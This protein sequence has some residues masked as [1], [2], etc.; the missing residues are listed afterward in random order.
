MEAQSVIGRSE[1]E[2]YCLGALFDHEL[3]CLLLSERARASYK[4]ACTAIL[5]GRHRVTAGSRE[6][7][8]LQA[9]TPHLCGASRAFF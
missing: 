2:Q 3:T 4:E 9:S 7:H 5:R 1:D 8:A 6:G